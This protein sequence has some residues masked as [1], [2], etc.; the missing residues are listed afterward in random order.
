M[1]LVCQKHATFPDDIAALTE[2][3][4]VEVRNSLFGRD[5]DALTQQIRAILKEK[6]AAPSRKVVAAIL[7]SF[8]LFIFGFFGL[9]P[10]GRAL[11]PWGAPSNGAGQRHSLYLIYS[12]FKSRSIIHEF[13]R[14]KNRS[15]HLN[16]ALRTHRILCRQNQTY[17]PPIKRV[18]N[19]SPHLNPALRTHRFFAAKTRRII[20]QSNG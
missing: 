20:R 1:A 10:S 15:P 18:K 19:R 13:K 14:V 6:H 2:R 4:A 8:A 16:P 11:L 17:H 12:S 9:Y 7:G 3:N 5:A